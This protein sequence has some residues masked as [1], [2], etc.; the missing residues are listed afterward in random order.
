MS[1]PRRINRHT[2]GPG[3][4]GFCKGDHSPPEYKIWGAMLQRC[5]NPR[6]R[7][8]PYYGGRGIKVCERWRE[9]Q[10][11]VH[12]LSDLGPQPHRR[13][14]IHRVN[15]D[16]DYDPSNVTW[17]NPKGQSRHRRSNRLITYAGRTQILV[18]W[19]EEFG[20]RPGTLWRRLNKGVSVEEALT[21]PVEPR[22][23]SELWKR[24]PHAKK[25]GPKPRPRDENG[26]VAVSQQ[27]TTEQTQGSQP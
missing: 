17:S 25:R 15:N 9:A 14:S 10:G 13:A 18:L 23:P 1:T 26:Q 21:R 20:I 4:H 3:K 6:C 24:D 27:A 12:F 5:Y 22:M 8:Y 16:G 11:F 7:E 19:A 2:K